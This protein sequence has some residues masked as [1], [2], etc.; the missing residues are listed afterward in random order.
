MAILFLVLLIAAFLCFLAATFNVAARINLL[1]LGFAL[2][3]LVPLIQIG[4]T[5]SLH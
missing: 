3:V 4:E 2:W 5:L 1:A